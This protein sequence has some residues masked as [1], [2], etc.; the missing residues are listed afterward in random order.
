MGSGESLRAASTTSAFERKF[1]K[2]AGTVNTVFFVLLILPTAPF[3]DQPLTSLLGVS[4]DRSLLA[5]TFLLMAALTAINWLL[6]RIANTK[7]GLF[8]KSV[9]GLNVIVFV[10]GATTSPFTFTFTVYGLSKVF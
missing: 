4:S 10:L 5:F 3:L 7:N 1:L 9:A 6:I 8:Y 2:V